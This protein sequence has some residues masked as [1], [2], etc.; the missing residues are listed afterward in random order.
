MARTR[1]PALLLVPLA[2]M[3]MGARAPELQL[4]TTQ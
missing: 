2:F 1:L 3:H 4:L